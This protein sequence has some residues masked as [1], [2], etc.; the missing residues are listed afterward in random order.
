M[1][2]ETL[3]GLK[4][5]YDPDWVLPDQAYYAQLTGPAERA[6]A[7]SLVRIERARLVT[8]AIQQQRH[9]VLLGDPG[10]GK[11]TVLRYLCWVLAQREL[12]RLPANITDPLASG[13]QSACLPVFLPLRTLAG[14]LATSTADSHTIVEQAVFAAMQAIKDQPM[15]D[16]LSQALYRG[17]AL[18]GFDGLD[19]VPLQATATVA[20]RETTLQAVK[21]FGAYY[22]QTTMV[23]T[24]RVRAY[25]QDLERCCGWPVERLAPFTQGQMRHFVPAWYGELV[26]KGQLEPAQAEAYTAELLDALTGK[27]PDAPRLRDM[28]QTPLLLTLMAWVVYDTNRLPRDR[29]ELYE[30]V[31]DL[32]LEQWDAVRQQQSLSTVI[33]VGGWNSERL[34]PLLSKLSYTAHRDANS[35]DGRGRLLAANLREELEDFLRA[36]GLTAEQAAAAAVRCLQHFDQRSGL[37]RPDREEGRVKEY[38][39]AHLTLQEHCAGR[40]IALVHEDPIALILQHRTDDRWREP[41]FLGMGLADPLYLNTLLEELVSREEDEK[42]KTPERWYRDLI[43]AAEIGAD[44]DWQHLQQKPRVKVKKLQTAL[45]DGLAQLLN[46]RT[47]ALDVTE[48]LRAGALLGPLGDPRF[49]ITCQQ[50]QQSLHQRTSVFGQPNGYWCSI[51]AGR[52]LVGGWGWQGDTEPAVAFD[53]PAFWIARYPITVAQYAAFIDA[54]GYE[55]HAQPWWPPQGWQWKQKERRTQ[56]LAWNDPDYNQPNQPVIGISW[57]EAMA[58]A[59]WLAAQLGEAIRLPSEAEWEAAAAYPLDAQ[60]NRRTYPWGPEDPTPE[61]AIYEDEQGRNLGHAAPVGV[62]GPGMAA[63][64]ALDMAGNVFE[65]CCSSDDGYPKESGQILRDGE[66]NEKRALKGSSWYYNTTF[67][68]CGARDWFHFDFGDLD[69]GFRLVLAPRP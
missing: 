21:A 4:K 28:A 35:S 60:G 55:A 66:S 62:C 3:P 42:H 19:E 7:R 68:P 38:E 11:S 52:Y 20:S 25:S 50:W 61:H 16:L 37:L 32:L 64:G 10:A 9:L 69:D 48:R 24:C 31:L 57:Y 1:R 33:G 39:F 26:G 59:N 56:P 40:Y 12:E 51:P 67:V 30:K 14:M 8:E 65:W 49:P 43:L 27:R 15:T 22:P 29:P 54:G 41:I 36:G 6:S 44:R 46:E 5:D 58:Y 2:G 53:L 17:V 47:P 13:E 34:L 63:C 45:R 18:L 23:L